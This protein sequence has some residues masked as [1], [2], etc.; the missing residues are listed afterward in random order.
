MVDCP[1][2]KYLA[3]IK[4]T[5]GGLTLERPTEDTSGLLG[6][7]LDWSGSE[8]KFADWNEL[9]IAILGRMERSWMQLKTFPGTAKMPAEQYNAFVDELNDVRGRFARLR[10]PWTTDAS[11]YGTLGWYWGIV[12][13]DAAWDATEEIAATT[14]IVIDAQCLRQRIDQALEDMGGNPVTPGST[15]HSPSGAS[16]GIL[17]TIALVAVG[18]G[19]VVG[20]VMLGRRLSR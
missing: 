14:S 1:S 6:G 7:A 4:A 20:T 3:E 5:A 18:G 12:A 19:L 15:A 13:P 17:G 8:Y 9:A 10:K 2:G 16:L 11:A